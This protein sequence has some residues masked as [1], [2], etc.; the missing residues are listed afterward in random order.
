MLIASLKLYDDPSV[1]EG[2]KMFF[3]DY[4]RE[5]DLLGGKVLFMSQRLFWNSDDH[6]AYHGKGKGVGPGHTINHSDYDKHTP[7]REDRRE[8][9][10][11]GTFHNVGIDSW[12]REHE[13]AGGTLVAHLYEVGE[14]YDGAFEDD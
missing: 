13:R 12:I 10:E 5:L 3:R 7:L 4:A 6:H 11:P 2:V 9:V 14:R 8:G 1:P